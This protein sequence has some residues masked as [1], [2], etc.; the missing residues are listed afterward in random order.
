MSNIGPNFRPPRQQAQ[1]GL[2]KQPDNASATENA[3]QST[4]QNGATAGQNSAPLQLPGTTLSGLF[5]TGMQPELA[6]ASDQLLLLLKNLLQMPKELAQLMALLADIAPDSAQ[7]MLQNLL[8]SEV[9]IPLDKLQQLL[10]SHGDAAQEKLL[11]LLQSAAMSSG[12]QSSQLG[13]MLGTLTELLQKAKESPTQALQSTMSLYLPPY[14]LH[15]PQAFT[16]RFEAGDKSNSEAENA[17][18]DD[19]AQLA[20]FITTLTLGQFKIS[21]AA[22]QRAPIEAVIHHEAAAAPFEQEIIRQTDLAM[23]GPGRLLLLFVPKAP[24]KAAQQQPPSGQAISEELSDDSHTQS[25]AIHPAGGISMS[26][27]YGA[28]ALIRVIFEMD[29][30][31]KV[32]LTRAM[33]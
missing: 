2:S 18:E 23:G 17:S 28:Y 8:E 27:L 4:T 14:P 24:A 16:L 7:A 9:P 29:T 11:K 3:Q 5:A 25:V 12:K 30:Q 10:L 13:E 31:N 15:P 20:L 22:Q 21:L 26:A 19:E 1:S 6:L 33:L 32:H